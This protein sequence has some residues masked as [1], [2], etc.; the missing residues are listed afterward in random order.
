MDAIILR[1][2]FN[3]AIALFGDA[4]HQLGYNFQ[5]IYLTDD[6]Y[7]FHDEPLLDYL[8]QVIDRSLPEKLKQK[9]CNLHAN[10]RTR[11]SYVLITLNYAKYIA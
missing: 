2:V 7:F 8:P 5:V 4:V 1:A 9:I 3:P 6:V 11:G 10:L